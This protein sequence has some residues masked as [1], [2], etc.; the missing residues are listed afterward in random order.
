MDSVT[1]TH[2][3]ARLL[4]SRTP[5]V[6]RAR[7]LAET[8]QL[9]LR[10]DVALLTLTGPGGV[11]KT[12][13]ALHLG[14]DLPRIRGGRRLR[15]AGG[16]SGGGAGR[17]P[18]PGEPWHQRGGRPRAPR[19]PD[20]GASRPAG[21]HHPRQLRARRRCG[22]ARLGA[23]R[24]LSAREGARRQAAC[25]LRLSA[26]HVYPVAPLATP[27]EDLAAEVAELAE[28]AAVALFVQRAAAVDPQIRADRRNAADV[29]EICRRLDGLPLAIEL[30]AAR[31]R[32][33]ALPALRARLANRLLLLTDGPRD[34]PPRLQLDAR[35]DRLELRPAD[36][37]EQSLF[38]RLAV[39]V[40]GF[41]LEAAE[42]VAEPE[43]S[44]AS[45]PTSRPASSTSRVPGR[46]QPGRA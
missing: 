5:L 3:S 44:P 17:R 31:T 37:A 12:R 1:L 38:R 20:G 23:A 24:E 45:T 32:I 6:G 15:V 39:F 8:S 42:A 29:A 46:R 28:T 4:R 18:H 7:E 19:P 10:P 25:R 40:D 2:D 27:N 36:A 26:E 9:M 13:L 22:P 16:G 35:C 30:A 11:G 43:C 14:V 21:A 34:R 41:T 33:L